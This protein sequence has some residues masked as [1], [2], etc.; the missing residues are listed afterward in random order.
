MW[1]AIFTLGNG[2]QFG[3]GLPVKIKQ[4]KLSG[5]KNATDVWHVQDAVNRS[6]LFGL[7]DFEGRT[8]EFELRARDTDLFAAFEQFRQA[9]E[10]PFAPGEET[11][12]AWNMEDGST[13]MVY[14]RPSGLEIG[15]ADRSFGNTLLDG[16]AKFKCSDQLIYRPGS[17]GQVTCTSAR[18]YG[19]WGFYSNFTSPLYAYGTK[20]AL[21]NPAT[22]E[23]TGSMPVPFTVRFYGPVD[24]PCLEADGLRLPLRSGMS[25]GWWIE[26]DTRTGKVTNQDGRA[27]YEFIDPAVNI[28]GLRLKPGRTD[29]KL[30]VGAGTGTNTAKAVITWQ[31]AL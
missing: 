16:A 20:E 25:S 18:G 28:R 23:V 7:S 15:D 21:A 11:T 13:C 24:T 29:V 19:E 14:G 6:D 22:V 31:S 9:W 8:I 17:G 12:L 10:H 2:Y 5:N 1:D 4:F 3:Y 30:N 27:A 26:V